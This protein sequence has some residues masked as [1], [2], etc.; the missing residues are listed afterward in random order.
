MDKKEPPW[1]LWLEG[2]S[3]FTYFWK[4]LVAGSQSLNDLVLK[5]VDSSQFMRF[6]DGIC[7]LEFFLVFNGFGGEMQ[8]LRPQTASAF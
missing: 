4:K 7:F 6:V 8:F 3:S 1:A 5:C 2:Y